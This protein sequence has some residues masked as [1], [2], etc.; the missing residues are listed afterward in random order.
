MTI[1]TQPLIEGLFDELR[2]LGAV[3]ST[4]DFSVNWLGMNKSYLRCL[5]ARNRKPSTQ[6]MAQCANRLRKASSQLVAN[7]GTTAVK[8][9]AKRMN[10]LADLCV[11]EV[12]SAC[13]S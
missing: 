2:A 9:V 1:E 8:K 3:R 7:N 6:V 5:R 10:Q 11:D 12:F 13:E 4:D